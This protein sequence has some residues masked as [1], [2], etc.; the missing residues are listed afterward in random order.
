MSSDKETFDPRFDPAFQPGYQ[1]SA[2]KPAR[3]SNPAQAALD[4]ARGEDRVVPEGEE[5]TTRR[6]P[7]P[8]ITALTLLSVLLIV[9]GV[10]AARTIRATFEQVDIRVALDYYSLDIL[11]FSAP[12][13]VAIGVATG[14]GVVFFYAVEWQRNHRS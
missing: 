10:I 6:R 3:S 13:A 9:G 12:L 2:D 5:T 8:F 11:K 1:A 4:G 7:N 14:I